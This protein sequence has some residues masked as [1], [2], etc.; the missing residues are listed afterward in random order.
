MDTIKAKL[1]VIFLI[2]AVI[3]AV[4]WWITLP[5]YP[6][7][8]LIKDNN[9]LNEIVAANPV[10]VV[11]VFTPTC[12]ACRQM[13]PAIKRLATEYKGRIFVAQLNANNN[14]ALARDLDIRG[15]PTT[16]VYVKG[17]PVERIVGARKYNELRKQIQK[18][19]PMMAK[20]SE[21]VLK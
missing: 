17:K 21:G 18:Y 20:P 19:E 5:V 7:L 1:T 11:E 2:L 8:P 12:P 16:L 3:I 4:V 15:V 13:A 10:A 14:G 9:H 6:N